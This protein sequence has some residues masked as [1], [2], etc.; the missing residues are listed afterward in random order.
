MFA[1]LVDQ[2]LVGYCKFNGPDKQPDRIMGLLRQLRAA[3]ERDLPDRDESLW[4]IG[5]DGQPGRSV[6]RAQLLAIARRRRRTS[7][8]A[9]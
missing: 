5:L 3:G 4:E 1:A 6:G 9:S 2:L 7:C 8:F